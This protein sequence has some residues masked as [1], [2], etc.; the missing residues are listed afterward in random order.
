MQTTATVYTVTELTQTIKKQL[1]SQF[2]FVSVKGEVTN[3]RAQS[4]GHLYFSLKDQDAQIGA[5]LFSGSARLLSRIPKSGDQIIIKGELNL[6]ALRGTYQIIV[7]E[8]EYAGVG[9][10]LLKLYQLKMKLEKQGWFDQAIKKQLP[11]Y[12]KTIGVVT[13]PTGSVIQDILHV[14]KKRFKGFHLIVNPVRVQGEHAAKEIAEA[15]TQFNTYHLADV[16]IVARGGGSL[17]D[18]WPFNEECVA[19]AIFTSH[20]PIISAI[21]HETDTTIADYVAD[22]RAPTPSAA[23]ALSVKELSGELEYLAQSKKRIKI[24]LIHKMREAYQQIDGIKRHPFF[25]SP[26][27]ILGDLFQK[28][29]GITE[30]INRKIQDKLNYEKMGLLSL[31]KQF[32]LLKPTT[33]LELLQEKTQVY[34]DLLQSSFSQYLE[35]YREKIHNFESEIERSTKNIIKMKKQSLSPHALFQSLDLRLK[36]EIDRRKTALHFLTSHLQ[37]IDPRNLLKKGYCIPFSK[38]KDSVIISIKE[39][40]VE[41]ELSLL[42]HDGHVLT[43]IEE[44]HPKKP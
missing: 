10:L 19:E 14:L 3:I 40:N 34:S 18:L 8:V 38:K 2:R 35:R 29:D 15:I 13:S 42:F 5:V 6:Y 4:S 39:I 24:S 41:E 31:K 11:P 25:S 22:V 44:I 32:Q 30:E 27:P 37:S 28:L 16:I 23:A 9:E 21:G 20:I 12:P 43:K 33:R 26:Y 7:R 36:K 1:E 17:E